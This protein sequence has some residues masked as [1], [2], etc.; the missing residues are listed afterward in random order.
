[1]TAHRRILV[2]EWSESQDPLIRH[3]REPWRSWHPGV[4]GLAGTLLLHG[5][6]LQTAFLQGRAHRI[7]T[8]EVRELGSS[9]SKAV[10]AESLEFIELPSDVK[11]D[12]RVF[13]VPAVLMNVSPIKGDGLDLP[14]PLENLKLNEDQQSESSV[15]TADAAEHARLAGIYSGQMKARIER[16]WTR[17]RTP[18]N[19]A[20]ATRSPNTVEYFH[21]QVQIG[22][23]AT[24]TVQEVLLPNCNGSVAWQRSLV[25]AIQ[26]SSPLPAPPSPAVFSHIVTLIFIGYP[27]VVGASNEGYEIATN[28]D[29]SRLSG[30]AR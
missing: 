9:L 12:T 8:P 17:P 29:D 2:S 4:I 22:Q 24:G 13:R 15:S 28:R 7:P 30:I 5:V 23:D 11:A 16:I 10:P 19:G 3:E 26:Q 21:C 25:L 1:M 20:G 18:V 6:A 14:L 27:Y